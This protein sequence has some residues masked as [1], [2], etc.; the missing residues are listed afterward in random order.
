VPI[1]FVLTYDPDA[2]QPQNRYVVRAQIFYGDQLRWTST[3][4][5]P[6][7]TQDSP[8]DVTIELEPVG[9]PG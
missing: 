4:A 7:I 5:Y 3:T 2:I 6:V 1:P 9:G 8:T